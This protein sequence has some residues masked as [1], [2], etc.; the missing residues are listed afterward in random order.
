M[1]KLH[2]PAMGTTL[3]TAFDKKRGM[4]TINFFDKKKADELAE[5]GFHYVEHKINANQVIYAFVDT[6][7]LREKLI[8]Q[9]DKCEYYVSKNMYL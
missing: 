7:Q 2:A 3:T 8:G 1:E 4:G 5:M 6:P 9:Y